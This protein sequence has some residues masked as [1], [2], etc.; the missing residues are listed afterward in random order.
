MVNQVLRV[1]RVP[2][3]KKVKQEQGV[4]LEIWD[5]LAQRDL[6]VTRANLA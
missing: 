4:I 5:H 3:V 1:N 2:L 6:W